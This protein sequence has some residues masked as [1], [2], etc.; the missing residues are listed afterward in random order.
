MFDTAQLF[1]AMLQNAF[2]GT[3][4]AAVMSGV[5]ASGIAT[6][7]GVALL[8]NLSR[9]ITGVAPAAEGTPGA[10]IHD[11]DAKALLLAKAM[12]AAAKAD[13]TIDE[14]ERL[15]I[16]NGL[17]EAGVSPSAR[18]W[19]EEQ[20]AAPSDIDA[21]VAE[22]GDPQLA[23]EV[24]TASLMAITVDTDAERN[25]LAALAERLGLR[26]PTAEAA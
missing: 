11:K 14:D 24:F 16:L 10:T 1:N 22:V 17:A 2:R 8:A 9:A 7:D 5:N 13:G 3:P 12:I 25:Y 21:L 18:S 19:V 23:S 20:M 26:R 15:N 4:M 6:A